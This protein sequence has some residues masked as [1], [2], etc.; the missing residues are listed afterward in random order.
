MIWRN[1]NLAWKRFSWQIQNSQT[2]PPFIFLFYTLLFTSETS[3][4]I[5]FSRWRNI[6]QTDK[7]LTWSL[8]SKQCTFKNLNAFVCWQEMRK[9]VLNV[10]RVPYLNQCSIS[11]SSKKQIRWLWNFIS[12]VYSCLF[13]IRDLIQRVTQNIQDLKIH[14]KRKTKFK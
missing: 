12:V 4:Y 8:V 13:H 3:I 11:S 10:K 14:E 2:H 7:T 6:H 5:T 1:A 9:T